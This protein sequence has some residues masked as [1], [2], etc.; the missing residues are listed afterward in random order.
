MGQERNEK[1]AEMAI[2]SEGSDDS[3]RRKL[4]FDVSTQDSM[5]FH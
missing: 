1:R 5:G 2:L 3:F 4:Y